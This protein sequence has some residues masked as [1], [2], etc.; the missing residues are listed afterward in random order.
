MPAA[1]PSFQTAALAVFL[2]L[3]AT[4]A[5]VL[6]ASAGG[7][8]GDFGGCQGWGGLYRDNLDVGY[9]PEYILYGS[10]DV[11]LFAP[12]AIYLPVCPA[13]RPRHRI[14]ARH[15]AARRAGRDHCACR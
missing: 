5:P 8:R 11:F 9:G 2:G 3:G 7:C 15:L 4:T 12:P 1:L 10:S 6:P 13:Y 14:I